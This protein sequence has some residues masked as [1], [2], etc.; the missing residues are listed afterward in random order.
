[1]AVSGQTAEASAVS[2]GTPHSQV[3]RIDFTRELQARYVWLGQGSKAE[4]LWGNARCQCVAGKGPKSLRA[5][6]HGYIL[7]ARGVVRR[8]RRGRARSL[9][10]AVVEM[11]G[12][13]C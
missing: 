2:S 4:R 8:R 12:C 6:P 10:S 13:K 5:G 9:C 3:G 1:M 7:M 11:K